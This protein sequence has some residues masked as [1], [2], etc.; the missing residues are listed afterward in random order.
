MKP[1]TAATAATSALGRLVPP[2]W[3][4]LA[5]AAAAAAGLLAAFIETLHENVRRGEELR[6]WQ[7]AG[8]ARPGVQTV[9]GRPTGG[10]TVVV[11]LPSTPLQR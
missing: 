9:A 1:R 4:T 5:L 3:L 7:R 2:L 11:A 6:Q 10:A 8:V